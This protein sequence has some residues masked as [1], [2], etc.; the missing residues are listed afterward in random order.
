MPRRTS[1]TSAFSRRDTPEG[2]KKTLSLRKTE[3]RRESRV[4]DAPAAARGV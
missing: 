1:H 2:C 3:W 4:S